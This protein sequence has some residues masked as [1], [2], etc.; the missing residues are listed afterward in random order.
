VSSGSGTRIS[1]EKGSGAAMCTVALDPLGGFRSATCPTAL[2]PASLLGGLRATTR[3]VVP[4]GTR[5]SSIK[6]S[7]ADLPVQLGQHV[8]NTHALIFKAPDI[9]AIMC[10]QDVWAGNTINVCK[11]C[12]QAA[13]VR[14]QCSASTVDHSP[15]TTTVPGDAIAWCHTAD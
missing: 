13:I 9:R 15:D 4:C 1:N 7:L 12:V 2:N 3:P 6:K 5:A 8:H 11:T 10:L 14:L